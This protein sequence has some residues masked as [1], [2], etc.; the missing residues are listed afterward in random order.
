ME[1]NEE[2]NNTFMLDT[3]AN[4]TAKDNDGRF[5]ISDERFEVMEDCKNEFHKEMLAVIPA[6]SIIVA[7]FAGDF[8]MYGVTE[9]D[10]V[11]HKVKV[12]ITELHKVYFGEFD[13]RPVDTVYVVTVIYTYE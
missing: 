3:L 5:V 7:D 2:M 1:Y 12:D 9:V 11:L 6:G 4:I 8:G 10:G 13:A